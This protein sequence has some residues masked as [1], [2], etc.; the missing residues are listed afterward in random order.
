MKNQLLVRVFM[1]K[2]GNKTFALVYELGYRQIY[3]SFVTSD[4]AEI[5]GI[6][7]ASL[8]DYEEGLYKVGE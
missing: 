5:L 2:K 4:I 3:L 8:L 1:N 6:S 7:V